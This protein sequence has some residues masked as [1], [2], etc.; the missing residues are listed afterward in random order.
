MADVTRRDFIKN[1][2]LLTGAIAAGFPLDP[3]RAASQTATDWVSLGK[4]GI[5]VTRLA[6]GTGT[7][8]GKI[9]RELGQEEFTRI[10]RH[11]YDRGI[12]FFETADAYSG[13]QGMLAEA[14]KGIP[15]D[16]YKLMTKF[17]WRMADNPQGTIDRLRKELNSDYFDI[18]LLH[19]VRTAGWPEEL[20]KLPELRHAAQA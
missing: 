11:A 17:R 9:Q 19:C 14:L 5:K 18:L 4:S 10:V 7:L 15:R 8:G 3:T 13:M 6:F 1:T 20:K 2:A 16:S 12:R